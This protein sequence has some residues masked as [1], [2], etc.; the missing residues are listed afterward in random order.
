M[1]ELPIPPE[2]TSATRADELLR[3]WIIDNRLVCSLRPSFWGDE[4]ERWGLLLADAL[5]H[6]C[7]ALAL[8]SSNDKTEL[9]QAMV[10]SFLAEIRNPTGGH[11]GEFVE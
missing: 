4:P 6:V 10:R 3:G 7:D 9:K 1:S 8:E 2:T 5:H 11:R